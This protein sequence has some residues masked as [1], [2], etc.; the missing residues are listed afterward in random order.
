MLILRNKIIKEATDDLELGRRTPRQQPLQHRTL[1]GIDRG[2]AIHCVGREH[3]QHL[4]AIA[5]VSLP[6]Y[7]LRL[8]QPVDDAS[9]RSRCKSAG[10]G[11]LTWS[12]STAGLQ[13]G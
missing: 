2:Q 8:L 12:H 1:T 3:D 11:E 9:N 13:Q 6:P 4:P 10:L 7:Q 5:I